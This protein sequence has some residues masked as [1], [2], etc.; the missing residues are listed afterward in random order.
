VDLV[1]GLEERA[2]A[3]EQ[4]EA[5]GPGPAFPEL[6]V[7]QLQQVASAPL[8]V[9]AGEGAGHADEIVQVGGVLFQARQP[10][11]FESREVALGQMV[12]RIPG[13]RHREHGRYQ[14][15]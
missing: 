9:V 8:L 7:E 6:L 14:I 11:S 15:L 1:G 3:L 12:L 13:N 5:R 2:H 10:L 4:L